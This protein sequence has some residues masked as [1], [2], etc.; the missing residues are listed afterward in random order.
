MFA[1]LK[2]DFRNYFSMATTLVLMLLLSLT[3]VR[4]AGEIDPAFNAGAY[5]QPAGTIQAVV[6]QPDGKV[7][8]GGDF[9]IVGGFLRRGLARSN[10]DGT[11]DTSFNPPFFSRGE[12]SPVFINAI[13]LQSNGKIIVAGQFSQLDGVLINAPIVRLNPDGSRLTTTVTDVQI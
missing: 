3:P 5:R 12:G 6:T 11:P 4:A 1:F 13:G 8:I 2:T 9:E 7:L 10:T